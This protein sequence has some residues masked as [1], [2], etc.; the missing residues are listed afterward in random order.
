MK[1]ESPSVTTTRDSDALLPLLARRTPLYHANVPFIVCWAQKSG[2]TAVLKWFLYHAGLLEEAATYK[3][4]NMRLGIHSYENKVLKARPGYTQELLYSLRS[5]EPAINFMRCP[6]ERVFSS[7]MILNN[8]M[9]LTMAKGGTV[10]PGFR[11]RQA[12]LE[13]TH[14]QSGELNSPLSFRQ[15]LLWLK[16]QDVNSLNPHHTPQYS[17]LYRQVQVT[18]YRLDDF[19]RATAQ[20]EEAF[21]IASSEGAQHTFSSGHHRHKQ[22]VPAADALAF[23]ENGLPLDR[24]PLREVPVVDRAL[25]EGSAFE[26]IIREIF[27]VDIAAYE[28]IKPLGTGVR[29]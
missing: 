13:F 15:Y 25:L 17:P 6:F 16:E 4:G 7:Y 21:S 2:C 28:R 9:F 11:L 22:P 8:N 14:G 29:A 19:D 26:P 18:H 12:V 5:G 10:T 1:E 27:A 3:S 24:F 23:L 20:V